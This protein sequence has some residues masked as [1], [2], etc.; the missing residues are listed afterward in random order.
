MRRGVGLPAGDLIADG[1]DFLLGGVDQA[2]HAAGGVEDEDDFD[3]GPIGDG[4]L[5]HDAQ[6]GARTNAAKRAAVNSLH[7]CDMR[8][9]MVKQSCRYPV[10]ILDE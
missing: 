5:L 1:P 3:I 7:F 9:S 6:L 2:A 4:G 8:N 10:N